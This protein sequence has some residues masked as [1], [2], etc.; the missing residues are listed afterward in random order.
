MVRSKIEVKGFE[1]RNYDGLMNLITLGYYPRFIKSA[2]SFINL[3][4]SATV[5]DIGCGTGRNARLIADHVGGDC[6]VTGIDIGTDMLNAFSRKQGNDLRLSAMKADIRDPFPFNNS[7]F[8]GAFMS[9]VLH[10]MEH[11][12]RLHVLEEISRV[13][14]PG[15]K[16]YLLD[17]R[18]LD[19]KSASILTRLI[20]RLEC[21][22]AS[23]FLTHN[24]EDVLSLYGFGEFDEKVFFGKKVR[25]LKSTRLMY[26][27]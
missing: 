9:F 22:L 13:L 12:D 27:E 25:I 26:T 15:G 6:R 20:F 3:P 17:Y 16:F 21:D 10:G 19:L 8:D 23:E 14:K 2:V 24:W 1:A 11:D 18:P 7:S 5:L 4:E